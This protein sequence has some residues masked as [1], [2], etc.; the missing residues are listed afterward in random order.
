M[1]IRDQVELLSPMNV[2]IAVINNVESHKVIN[3]YKSGSVEICGPTFYT[4][5]RIQISAIL[6]YEGAE[7]HY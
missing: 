1:I 3:S 4:K 2:N 7:F 6:V 5:A